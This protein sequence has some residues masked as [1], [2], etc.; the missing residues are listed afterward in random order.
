MNPAVVVDVGNSFV[1]WGLCSETKVACMTSLPADDFDAY[2]RQ[3]DRWG[4]A[5]PTEWAVCGVQPQWCDRL[6]S[7]L[8]SHGDHV[9]VIDDWRQL[10]LKVAL[11]HPERVGIDRLLNAAAALGSYE[12]FRSP[13]IVVSVGTAVCVDWVE[14]DYGFRGGAIFP[15]FHLMSQ[16]LHEHTAL[17]P[18][19][20]IKNANPTLPGLSTTQAIEAGVYY[21]VVGGINT[22]VRQLSGEWRQLPHI[23]L[24][25]GGA[26]LI[27]NA[28]EGRTEHWPEMTL[29]G[30]RLTAL[31]LPV[32][33]GA[34]P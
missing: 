12:R 32:D 19:V 28:I 22:L 16:S 1:K 18:L 21:A 9:W 8:R 14:P 17:L 10:G 26:A 33:R 34:I 15:G 11:N 29:E 23:F 3:R 2:T 25:G 7:W 31:S 6:V 13:A 5:A 30:I 24:T 4:I 20:E 27:H